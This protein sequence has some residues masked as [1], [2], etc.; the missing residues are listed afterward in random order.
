MRHIGEIVGKKVEADYLPE[1]AGDVRDSL[2]DISAARALI[3]YE[4]KVPVRDGLA[5]TVAAFRTFTK[6]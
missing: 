2:A 6:V 4:V 3:G 5:K 1:R